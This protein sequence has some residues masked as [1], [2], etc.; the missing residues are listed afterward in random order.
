[1]GLDVVLYGPDEVGV[2]AVGLS[3]SGIH[4]VALSAFESEGALPRNRGTMA[5]IQTGSS[6]PRP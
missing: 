2:Q 1:M 5:S 4:H 6:W 3:A